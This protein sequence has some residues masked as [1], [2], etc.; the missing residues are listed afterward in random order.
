MSR[1]L[2]ARVPVQ[3]PV[4][5]RGIP[6]K[7]SS[8]TNKSTAGLCLKGLSSFF[9]LFQTESEEA[10]DHRLIFAPLQNLA[11][12]E[13]DKWYW[14]HVSNDGDNVSRQQEEF[15]IPLHKGWRLAAQSGVPWK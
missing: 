11:G 3:A 9:A 13:I 1:R 10:P 15:Q 6:T 5:G 7:S 8:A 14:E 12:E 2:A 4:P